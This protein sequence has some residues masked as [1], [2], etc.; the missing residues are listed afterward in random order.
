MFGFGKQN[1][2]IDAFAVETCANLL[3]RFHPSREAELGGD[4]RK[5]GATL[6]N[7]LTDLQ[8]RLIEFQIGQKLGVYGKARLLRAIQ[9]ELRRLQYSETFVEAT[10]DLLVPA[11]AARPR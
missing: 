4:R 10:T 3:K 2:A 7:A 8:Q 9:E 5:S 1:A 11:T 6:G